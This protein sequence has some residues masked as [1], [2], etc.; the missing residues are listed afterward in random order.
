MFT[1]SRPPWLSLAVV[2]SL[3]LPGLFALSSCVVEV[4]RHEVMMEA[5]H[6]E[7]EVYVNDAPPSPREEVIVGVAPG[8]GY[9]WVG[10]YWSWHNSN[11]YWVG[12]RWVARPRP[13]AVWFPGHWEPRG[14]GHA[15]VGGHWR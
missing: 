2:P 14:R 9:V 8:P 4:P 3:C 15:W 13:S 7:V 11:W 10:G 1:R 6:P 5:S 12:G